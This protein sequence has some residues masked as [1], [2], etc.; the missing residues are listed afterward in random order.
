MIVCLWC[1]EAGRLGRAVKESEE[2]WVSI[3]DREMPVI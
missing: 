2:I 3:P 1:E